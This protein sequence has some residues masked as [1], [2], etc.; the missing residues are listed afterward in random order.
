MVFSGTMRRE[1][2][3]HLV[4]PTLVTLLGF[5]AVPVALAGAGAA[6]AGRPALVLAAPGSGGAVQVIDR[7]GG[8]LVG[9]DRAAIG[10]MAVFE[11]QADLDRARAAGAW[12]LI[13]AQAIAALCAG[14]GVTG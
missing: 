4:L 12:I 10:Q 6:Q 5:G 1:L 7:A 3:R 2:T 14:T 9:L 8:R 13:D 11:T